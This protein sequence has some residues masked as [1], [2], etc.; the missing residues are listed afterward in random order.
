MKE[1]PQQFGPTIFFRGGTTDIQGQFPGQ[2]NPNVAFLVNLRGDNPHSHPSGENSTRYCE[3]LMKAYLLKQ[4]N[5]RL[6]QYQSIASLNSPRMKWHPRSLTAS[7]YSISYRW[8]C[9]PI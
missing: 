8:D 7:A 4:I 9:A 2:N 1:R 3:S 6:W 5:K